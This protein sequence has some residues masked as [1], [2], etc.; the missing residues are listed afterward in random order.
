MAILIL[1]IPAEAS[2]GA[3]GG[4]NPKSTSFTGIDPGAGDFYTYAPSIV[5]TSS[6]TRDLLYCGNLQSGIVHDHIMETQA[7]LTSGHWIYSA[8]KVVFGPENGPKT[9]G[10]FSYHACEPELISGSFGFAGTRYSWALFFTAESAPSNSTNQIG[11]AFSNSPTGPFHADLTPIVSTVDDYGDND[12]PNHCPTNYAGQ[13]LYCLGQPTATTLGGGRVVLAYTGNAGSPGNVTHPVVGI[14]LRELNLSNVPQGLCKTCFVKLTSGTTEVPFT[15]KGLQYYTQ[16]AAL[17][18]DP[19]L[20]KFVMT[21][22][23]GPEDPDQDGPPVTPVVTIASISAQGLL[24]GRGTWQINGNV[25]QC[26]SGYTYNHNSGMVRTIDG[27]IPPGGRLEVVYTVAD[28]DLNG[29]WGV[30]DYRMWDVDAPLSPGT[31]SDTYAAA[32]ADCQGMDLVSATGAVAVSGTAKSFGSSDR[33]STVGFALT[34]DR[35]GYYL[36]SKQGVVQAFG[37]AKNRGS[38]TT[39]PAIGIGVD[40]TTGGYWVAHAN[41]AVSG[42]DAPSTTS[43]RAPAAAFTSIPNGEG[44][45]LVSSTGQVAAYGH[46]QLFGSIT[47]PAGQ[48]V[49]AI[50]STPTGLGYYIVT[51]GGVIG[52][53]G[54]A[55]LFGPAHVPASTPIAAMTVDPDGV[56]YWLATTSGSLLGYG[57]VDTRL[58]QVRASGPVAA[59][60]AS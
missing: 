31:G 16:N 43:S 11:V 56:G 37:D 39:S 13:T 59:L 53:F 36:V 27:D 55:Q 45:Y 23:A 10:F 20:R 2:A 35:Q 50:A 32:S 54:D 51:T 26:L 7:H 5:Q 21:Y 44:Y 48:T 57:A 1:L 30:W 47:V 46:A 58:A 22:D 42:F 34:P 17:A 28:N 38:S 9:G 8:P 49:A 24:D 29:I 33:G 3:S 40:A 6:T 19:T 4:F 52:A 60:E 14:V 41:G 15:Q 18:Y 12:Y 25:G